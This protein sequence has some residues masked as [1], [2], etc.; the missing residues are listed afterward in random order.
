MITTLS[1]HLIFKE[2]HRCL[3]RCGYALFL[4]CEPSKTYP[5]FTK[6]LKYI[7]DDTLSTWDLPAHEPPSITSS[8]D[9][10]SEDAI[11]EVISRMNSSTCAFTMQTM[12][13][14]PCFQSLS[15][16]TTSII[17]SSLNLGIFATA[18]KTSIVKPL[19]KKFNLDYSALN[20][21]PISTVLW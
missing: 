4:D 19:L 10:M 14:K 18:F 6:A 9:S 8:I 15:Q 5:L 16:V 13:F 17:N 3:A 11:C 20:Y 12:L 2:R 1:N 7:I 21:R